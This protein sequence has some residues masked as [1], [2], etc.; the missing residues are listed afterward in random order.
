MPSGKQVLLNFLQEFSQ[1]P[2]DDEEAD[3]VSEKLR[4]ALLLHGSTPDSMWFHVDRMAWV[5]F[6]DPT[7]TESITQGLGIKNKSLLLSDILIRILD[8]AEDDENYRQEF[9]ELS[10]VEYKSALEI[11]R[12]L[13]TSTNFYSGLH[14]V[15]QDSPDEYKRSVE[16]S[17]KS[18]HSKLDLFRKDPGDF[19]GIEDDEYLEKIKSGVM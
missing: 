6:C 4:I 1:R 15:E 8:K 13:I 12:L 5:N 7:F 11:I 10:N 16:K 2:V 19:L 14:Q 18:Y 17:L 3:E 9:D